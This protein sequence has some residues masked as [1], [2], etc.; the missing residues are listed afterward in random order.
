M[1]ST[2][3]CPEGYPGF[4]KIGVEV[5]LGKPHFGKANKDTEEF[6]SKIRGRGFVF[7]GIGEN[8]MTFNK[9]SNNEKF[10]I[11]KIVTKIASQL[12]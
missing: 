5:K 8:L 4:G 9:L 6:F 12:S 3:E 1:I 2:N 7:K 11:T 10:S